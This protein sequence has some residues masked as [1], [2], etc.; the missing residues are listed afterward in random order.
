MFTKVHERVS[1]PL[2]GPDS[3]RIGGDTEDVHVASADLDH[4]EHAQAFEGERAVHSGSV[5]GAV[6]ILPSVRFPGSPARTRR[7]TL[8]APLA[9]SSSEPT[10]FRIRPAREVA[11]AMTREDRCGYRHP[12][13]T[14]G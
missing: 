13:R 10:A 5:P 8:I 12:G 9:V 2:N 11:I 4:E 3:V 7:A 14:K 1:G 6:S